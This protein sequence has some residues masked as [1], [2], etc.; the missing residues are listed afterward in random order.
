MERAP[1]ELDKQIHYDRPW[2]TLSSPIAKDQLFA[3][4]YIDLVSLEDNIASLNFL[5]KLQF[6]FHLELY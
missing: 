2:T 3:N 5:L 4:L 1:V 6:L